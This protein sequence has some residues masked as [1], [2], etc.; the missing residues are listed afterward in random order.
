MKKIICIMLS[1]LM[2]LAVAGCGEETSIDQIAGELT[3]GQSSGSDVVSYTEL[4][5]GE[6]GSI[7]DYVQ[8]GSDILPDAVVGG[9]S[10]VDVYQYARATDISA[11]DALEIERNTSIS[12]SYVSYMH[13]DDSVNDPV[14]K[15]NANAGFAAMNAMG[16]ETSAL[17]GEFGS[18][19][20]VTAIDIKQNATGFNVTTVYLVA[21]QKLIAFGRGMHVFTFE[22]MESVG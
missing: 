9:W 12:I 11:E 16:I 19:A 1:A 10:V 4:P 15:V 5:G 14:Y 3:G 13:G 21:G 20:Q 22:R 17:A 18:D 7:E 2:M 6:Q 8:E